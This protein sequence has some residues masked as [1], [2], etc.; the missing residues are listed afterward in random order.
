MRTRLLL[1]LSLLGTVTVA[2]FAIPLARS[3]AESRTGEFALSRN[4]DLERFVALAG[5]YARGEDPGNLFGELDTYRWLYGETVGVVST[6]GAANYPADL[7]RASPQ[8]PGAVT[9]ALRNQQDG[10]TGPLTPWGP[11]QVV[12][13]RA[14]GTDAQITG[15][16]VLV[17]DTAQAREQIAATWVAIAGGALA[18][19]AALLGVALGV[20]SWILRPLSRLST[21]MRELVSVLP[22]GADGGRGDQE[23]GRAHG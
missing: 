4:A 7:A 17:A 6:R 12:F 15:A 14:T 16:V 13:A 10:L 23:I 8:I 21:G 20:S 9:R 2:S 1:V 19:L 11:E 22:R 3:V 5:P 18:A